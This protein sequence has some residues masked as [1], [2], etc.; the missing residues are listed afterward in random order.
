MTINFTEVPKKTRRDMHK[1]RKLLFPNWKH[2]AQ[3]KTSKKLNNGKKLRT[4]SSKNVS[5]KSHSA[6]NPKESPM[7][8][9]L[10]ISCK[11]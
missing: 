6:E 5:G 3:T 2:L 9:K 10:S 11:N 7:L 1:A 8:A 4:F